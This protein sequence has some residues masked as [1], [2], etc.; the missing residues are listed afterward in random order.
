MARRVIERKRDDGSTI[1]RIDRT[2]KTGVYRINKDSWQRKWLK[3]IELRGVDSLPSGLYTDGRGITAAGSRLLEQL[4]DKYGTK[5]RLCIAGDRDSTIRK[6]KKTVKV[7]M[8][9]DH[10]RALNNAYRGLRQERN[11]ELRELV[12]AF[13]QRTFPKVF[14]GSSKEFM[15]YAPGTLARILTTPTLIDHLSSSDRKAIQ[16]FIPEFVKGMDFSLRSTS[17]ITFAKEGLGA[18]QTIY[19]GKVVEEYDKKLKRAST[20][21]TWQR[22][23]RQHILI[24]LHS[25][26]AVIEKQSVNLDGKYPDFMLIDPYGYLDIYEIKK[27]Q[28]V[29]LGYD[30][31]RN[32]HYW[33]VE[34]CKAI[35]QVENYIDQATQHRLELADKVR[36]ELGLQ[37]KI[38]RPRGFIIAGT[39]AQLKTEKMQEDFRVLNDSLKNIDIIFYDDLLENI[40][41]MLSRFTDG[42]SKKTAKRS[43]K[44]PKRKIAKKSHGG[45]LWQ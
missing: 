24:L 33:A 3:E 37:I 40:K 34:V 14:R 9:H 36:R 41:A 5:L 7:T 8:G 13:L 27:P 16:E 44:K 19:L 28:T 6:N 4:S 1:Y 31:S 12:D 29:M 26:S 45:D 35:S 17:N 20:E 38:V 18:T 15:S 10:L 42:G 25:Y 39:R 30:K 23:L 21:S 43:R 11:Q 32:N 22:F 2:R